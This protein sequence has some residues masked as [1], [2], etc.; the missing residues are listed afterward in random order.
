MLLLAKVEH[1]VA[2][3]KGLNM[4]GQLYH[5]DAKGCVAFKVDW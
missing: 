4:K 3:L 1:A 2:A 5:G